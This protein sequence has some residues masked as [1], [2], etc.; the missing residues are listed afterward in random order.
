MNLIHT[1]LPD[2]LLIE[3][4]VFGDARGYFKELY[5]HR[6]YAE[7]GLAAVFVQDNYSRSCRGTLRGL[8][9]QLKHPQGK[10]IQ[11]LHGEIYDVAVDVRRDSPTFGRW[12]SA[13][14][15][16][17]NHRQ[18]YVP[19]GFAHG[20]Y[21]TSESADVLYKCTDYYAPEHERTLLWNDG[22]VN[23]GWPLEGEPI[24]SAKDKA[25][26]RLSELECFESAP[27]I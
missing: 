16:A 23:V 7:A 12:T 4:K 10:L 17:E 27:R 11:V 18:L 14:L 19:A 1:E 26:V 22:E 8:H 15:S 25:G 21:V 5:H 20:F 3:P 13:V 24:L 2:V 9:F 6:R